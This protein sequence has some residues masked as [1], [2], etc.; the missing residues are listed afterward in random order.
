MY[1]SGATATIHT[2]SRPA[3]KWRK[4][5]GVAVA[6]EVEFFHKDDK[7]AALSRLVRGFRRGG[8]AFNSN[9]SPLSMV[10]GSAPSY[11]YTYIGFGTCCRIAE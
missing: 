3:T 6:G 1:G 8:D 4:R 11:A 2:K 5:I 7:A 9:L 10:A